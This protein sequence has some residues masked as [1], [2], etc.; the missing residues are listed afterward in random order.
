MF[1]RA[2][3]AQ[4]H[5]GRQLLVVE[6]ADSEGVAQGHVREGQHL[7]PDRSNIAPLCLCGLASH[8]RLAV[9]SHLHVAIDGVKALQDVVRWDYVLALNDLQTM[10]RKT[11]SGSAS[12]YLPYCTSL[13]T[14]RAQL[15]S[16]RIPLP[17]MRCWGGFA[18]RLCH[19]AYPPD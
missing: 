19:C 16:V 8:A 7:V 5:I 1:R 3:L 13:P 4:Q 17:K 11:G 15:A 12:K 2:C 10:R 6:K 14:L 9:H 18:N